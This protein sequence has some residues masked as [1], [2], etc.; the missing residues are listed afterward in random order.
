MYSKLLRLVAM[1]KSDVSLSSLLNSTRYSIQL[2]LVEI[3]DY[4]KSLIEKKNGMFRKNLLGKSLTYGAR[5]VVLTKIPNVAGLLAENAVIAVSLASASFIQPMILCS[6]FVIALIRKE[7][8]TKLRF[9]GSV[10]CMV[11]IIGFQVC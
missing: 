5:V 1:I 8:I 6:L 7:P 9:I 4:Y 10:I 3:Y 11:G 2:V